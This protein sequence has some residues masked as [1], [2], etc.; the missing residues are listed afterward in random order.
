VQPHFQ[1]PSSNI[2]VLPGSVYLPYQNNIPLMPQTGH[3]DLEGGGNPGPGMCHPDSPLDLSTLISK[4]CIVDGHRNQCLSTPYQPLR[5][6]QG[7]SNYSDSSWTIYTMYSKIAGDED[8]KMVEHCLRDAD[9]TLIFVS[10]HVS[11]QRTPHINW[12]T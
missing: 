8:S 2:K 10:P 1:V 6:L 4:I 11:F 5:P 7:E 9:G 3:P 12:E